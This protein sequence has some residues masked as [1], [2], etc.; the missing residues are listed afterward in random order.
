LRREPIRF[1]TNDPLPMLFEAGFRHVR[2][3]SF[4]EICLSLTG[5]YLRERAFRFQ[6][7]CFASRARPL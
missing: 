7:V 1:G 6:H 4:D 5:T 3:Q 2:S